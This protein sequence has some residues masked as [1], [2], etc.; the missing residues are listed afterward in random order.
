MNTQL[1]TEAKAFKTVCKR[2]ESDFDTKVTDLLQDGW[3]LFGVP[4][5]MVTATYIWTTQHLIKE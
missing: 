2:D 3:K 5:T 4:H 1:V